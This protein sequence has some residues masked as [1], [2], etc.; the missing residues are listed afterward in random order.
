[1]K[2]QRVTFHHETASVLFTPSIDGERF[3]AFTEGG[4][5]I[6]SYVEVIELSHDH[7]RAIEDGDPEAVND[8]WSPI[9]DL[10]YYRLI[11]GTAILSG[12]KGR[13]LEERYQLVGDNIFETSKENWHSWLASANF[14]N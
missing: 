13:K 4:S 12:I 11:A 3:I 9:G 7:A 5:L 1:M 14:L 6:A 8:V 10:G 2:D